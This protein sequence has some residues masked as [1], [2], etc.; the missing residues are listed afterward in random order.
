MEQLPDPNFL[1]LASSA[2]NGGI[3]DTLANSFIVNLAMVR[4]VSN[5]RDGEC[6]LHFSEG[7]T[8]TLHGNAANELI[9]VL[10]VRTVL[11]DG[12]PVKPILKKAFKA[13]SPG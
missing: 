4:M 9:A 7:H 3:E 12:T 10:M 1:L 6:T 2:T 13:Q 5:M 8:I 11:P